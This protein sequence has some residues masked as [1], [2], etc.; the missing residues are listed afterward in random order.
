MHLF[1]LDGLPTLSP[2]QEDLAKRNV[3]YKCTTPSLIVV[4]E[5]EHFLG[6]KCYNCNTIYLL[7]PQG[8]KMKYKAG[9]KVF[10]PKYGR[11]GTV[12]DLSGTKQHPYYVALN[13]PLNDDQ[14]FL[15]EAELEP[16]KQAELTDVVLDALLVDLHNFATEI[17][18]MQFGLPILNAKHAEGMRDILRKRLA[19][20]HPAL[21][22]RR[23]TSRIFT[24]LDKEMADMGKL[25]EEYIGFRP[26]RRNSSAYQWGWCYVSDSMQERFRKYCTEN[27]KK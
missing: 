19:P 10:V 21:P 3:C 7:S 11:E 9:D 26:E 24:D 14:D 4:G 27:K 25:F 23:E 16:V 6:K 20:A 18:P 12:I 22:E 1:D 13:G 15:A 8:D 5:N 2:E 17:Q